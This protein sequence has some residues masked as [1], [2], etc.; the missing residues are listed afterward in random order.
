MAAPNLGD[1]ADAGWAELS[2]A[3]KT[4]IANHYAWAETLPQRILVNS[5]FLS[6]AL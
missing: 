5:N 6:Q 2:D 4:R 1:F 3:D